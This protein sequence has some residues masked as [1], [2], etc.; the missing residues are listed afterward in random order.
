MRSYVAKSLE[1]LGLVVVG[2]ALLIGLQ[3]GEMERELTALGIGAAVFV[4]GYLL[5]PGA[6]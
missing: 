2:L 3:G 5:E 1:A 4:L 6:N